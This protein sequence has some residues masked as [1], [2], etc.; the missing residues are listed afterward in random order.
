MGDIGFPPA[1]SAHSGL[2]GGYRGTPRGR[3]K[4]IP[5]CEGLQGGYESE[6]NWLHFAF[7]FFSSL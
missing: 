1:L 2:G 5:A 6:V 7:F 4:V 3:K